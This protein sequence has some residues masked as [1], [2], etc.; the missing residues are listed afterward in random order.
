MTG[1]RK[2]TV[3]LLSQTVICLALFLGIW[4]FSRTA[5]SLFV[6]F[7][8]ELFYTIDFGGLMNALKALGRCVLPG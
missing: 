7:K 2:F 3:T 1:L 8:E 4:I 6:R 5:P